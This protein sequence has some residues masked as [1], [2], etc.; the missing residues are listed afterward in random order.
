MTIE[1]N[2]FYPVGTGQYTYP[3][4]PYNATIL[5]ASGEMQSITV[6]SRSDELVIRYNGAVAIKFEEP[7]YHLLKA[8]EIIADLKTSTSYTNIIA[9]VLKYLESKEP[10]VDRQPYDWLE[11]KLDSLG[12]TGTARKNIFNWYNN[13]DAFLTTPYL[14]HN[15][16]LTVKNVCG[17]RVVVSP[18]G[19]TLSYTKAKRIWVAMN[20]PDYPLEHSKHTV[21]EFQHSRQTIRH[22]TKYRIEVH[23]HAVT[24]GCQTIPR[25]AIA[26]L[27]AREG[28]SSKP[29]Q[30]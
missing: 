10:K 22:T 21:G 13:P 25:S 27:A 4:P 16:I 18:N 19:H 15:E 7:D 5:K 14:L 17:G 26:D 12:K 23:N 11:T 9:R 20:N 29:H 6:N 28:W 2:I 3:K 24:I 1:Y 8:R 30:Y